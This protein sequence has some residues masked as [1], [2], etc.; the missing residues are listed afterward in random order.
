MSPR[1]SAALFALVFAAA[2]ASPAAAAN[3]EH[4]QLMADI[5][6]LQEQAQLL[7]NMLGTINDSI[8]AVNARLDEQGNA[9]RKAFADQKLQTDT[10]QGDLRIVREKVDDNNVRIASLTQEIEALRQMVQQTASAPRVPAPDAGNP[11]ASGTAPTGSAPPVVPP[12]MAPGTS[13]TQLY[14]MA[15]GDYTIG[16]WELAIQGFES[17]IRTFPRSTLADEAQVKIGICYDYLGQKQKALDAFDTAIRDYPGGKSQPTAYYRKGLA[18]RDLR[19]PDKAR[20]AFAYVVQKFP[21]SPE[22][23]LSKQALDRLKTP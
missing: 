17:Y 1:I 8:K 5:R 11:A 16:Q 3:K 19:Q 9:T 2:S 20:E 22:A 18:L 23:G 12:A 14:E 4:Q 10:L 15:L 6:M 21:D 7:Q 13:P